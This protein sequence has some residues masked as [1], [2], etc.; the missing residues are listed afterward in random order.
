VKERAEEDNQLAD[1]LTDK[2]HPRLSDEAAVINSHK[3]DSV[4]FQRANLPTSSVSSSKVTGSIAAR[5][6]V[7]VCAWRRTSA[8]GTSGL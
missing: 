7:L 1:S 5:A 8:D 3:A 6:M 2:M 4:P